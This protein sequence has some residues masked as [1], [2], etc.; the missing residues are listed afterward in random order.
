MFPIRDS[1]P[2]QRVPV[3]TWMLIVG[4]LA[5]F[6]YQLLLDDA[7]FNELVYLCGIVPARWL[8]PKWAR[9]MGFPPHDFWPFLTS[10]FLHGSWLHLI[11]NMWALAIFGDNVEDRL[12]HVRFLLLYVLGG[13]AAGLL[14]F[15][16]NPMSQVPTIGASGAIAGVMGAYFVLFPR[17]RVL[18]LV[19]VGCIPIPLQLPA[20]V[21]LGLWFVLQFFSA[22][23]TLVG[24]TRT[25][26]IAWWAHVGGFLAGIALLRVLAPKRRSGG[27][28]AAQ[29]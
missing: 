18:T 13:L 8:D 21:Y 22:T 9:S 12:G 17:A 7:R 24:S 23:A 25:G 15:I 16:T 11:G 28:S 26:G 3:V 29:S 2:I 5:A 20:I 14:H 6:V 19:P 10:M 1:Q 27:Y 4:T